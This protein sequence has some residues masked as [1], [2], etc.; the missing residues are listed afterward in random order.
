MTYHPQT[1]GTKVRPILHHDG[2][3][4]GEQPTPS[5]HLLLSFTSKYLEREQENITVHTSIA[6]LIL[7]SS[8][9]HL[10][11]DIELL[12]D[13]DLAQVKTTTTPPSTLS[14]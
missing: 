14:R 13:R 1:D 3:K 9:L 4:I 11:E 2:P 5:F 7:L 12:M 10:H 6:R 8:G